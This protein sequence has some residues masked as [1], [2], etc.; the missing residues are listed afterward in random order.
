MYLSIYFFTYFLLFLGNFVSGRKEG[1][2]KLTFLNGD[3]YF[4]T[5]K[6]GKKDGFGTYKW[7][8]GAYYQGIKTLKI[9]KNSN[10]KN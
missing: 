1:E 10:K 2:G 7:S 4:G 9:E 5:W 6:S 3:E 8:D